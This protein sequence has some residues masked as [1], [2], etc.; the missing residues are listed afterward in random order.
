MPTAQA[1]Y[2]ELESDRNN[3]L[4][5]ARAS[6]RLTL[7][8]L[9]PSS[10]SPDNKNMDSYPVPWNGIGARGVLNLAS[11]MLLALLPPTQQFF[12]FSLDQAELTKQGVPPE[13][14]SKF[15][16]AL[17]QVERLVLREIEASN[18]RVVFHEALL[19]LL[20]AGN[21]LLYVSQEGLRCYHLSR[22]VCSRDSMGNPVEAVIC[23]VLPVHTLPQAAK[24]LLEQEDQELKG[25]LQDEPLPQKDY[26]KTAKIF[27][28]IEWK[29][30]TVHWHQ[31]LK[32]Q[33]I[34]GT[35]GRAPIDVSPWLPL[36][37]VRVDG[38]P[39]GIGYI[40][41]AALADLQT[42]EALAQA[43][44]EGALASSKLLFLVRPSGVTKAADLA[45]APNGSF[46]TGDINDVQALQLQKSQDLQVAMQ[47]KQQIEARLS[48]AFMLADVRDSERTTAEEVRLQ[49]LQIE[50]SLGS[51]Y[52]VL[53]VEFQVPYV[54]RKLDIL[55]RAKKVPELPKDLVKP[56]MT[57][58]LAAVGR[59]NDLEQIVRFI[60]TLGQ[61]LG[62][63]AL[64]TFV[65]PSELITRLAYSMG[66]DVLGLVKTEDELAQ[67]QQAAQQQA[68]QQ[69][70]MQSSMADPQKLANAAST[71]QEMA[72]P[73]QEPPAEE[74]A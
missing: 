1:R 16:E 32:G 17:S 12:R 46:V 50:N 18:D 5:R 35:E 28:Y 10:N 59:G 8:W 4:E 69:Q 25:I 27:T 64:Q 57:V 71:V 48:Q 15:E 63:E 43:V 6:A 14:K 53:Q 21:A 65:N 42:V 56:V 73:P 58:G 61:T 41:A 13:A 52:S 31:E 37:M 67:E 34:P 62:P 72:A 26:E 49:A 33:T 45:K 29:G 22:Y 74:P 55:T 40:E 39:Y 36:R 9:V 23:E 11:R 20:V 70:L 24:D 44:A 3:F 51:I 30:K 2:S 66:I 68:Q 19:H 47:G 38:Q 60:T 54:S 7:P